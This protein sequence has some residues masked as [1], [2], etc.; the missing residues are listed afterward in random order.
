MLAHDKM[1]LQK[2]LGGYGIVDSQKMDMYIKANWIRRWM[3]IRWIKDYLECICI[4][5]EYEEPDCV[6]I[7]D[8]HSMRDCMASK[9]IMLRWAEYKGEFY[10]VGRNVYG[11]SLFESEFVIGNA[12]RQKIRVFDA[13]RERELAVRMRRLRVKDMMDEQGHVKD[14]Q[15][16][17][18]E[19]GGLITFV[20]F[21]RIRTE[22]YTVDCKS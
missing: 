19:I 22:L 15:G 5:G 12:R 21:F 4:K 9:I 1:F 10:K 17:E 6:N 7:I 11:A 13:E 16:M 3:N 2:E 14:K 20:E 18:R 8:L